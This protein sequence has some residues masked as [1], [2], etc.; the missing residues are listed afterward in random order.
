MQSDY[1]VLKT[2]PLIWKG[3]LI[4]A[5][6][7]L[8]FEF[9]MDLERK[10]IQSSSFSLSEPVNLFLEDDV[11]LTDI[12]NCNCLSH[13]LISKQLEEILKDYHVLFETFPVGLLSKKTGE[14]LPIDYSLFHLQDIRNG[15][16]KDRSILEYP[17][18]TTV[19]N[20]LK[21]E[22]SEEIIN[23]Q[24]YM[25]REK[26][27]KSIIYLHKTIGLALQDFGIT[28]F[29]LIPVDDFQLIIHQN[30][31]PMMD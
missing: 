14:K 30:H 12:L 19:F 6:G 7:D 15:L 5:E 10:L 29:K 20:V 8:P 4:L 16:D 21:I 13:M 27:K 26:I 22:L 1:F 9:Q 3:E 31:T 23:E 24:P 2:A 28:G 11:P 18:H 17:K 25:F